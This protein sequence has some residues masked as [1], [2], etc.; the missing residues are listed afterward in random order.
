MSEG[1]FPFPLPL[2]VLYFFEFFLHLFLPSH[3]TSMSSRFVYP[4]HYL[5]LPACSRLGWVGAMASAWRVSGM[6][7]QDITEKGIKFS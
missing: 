7:R 6:L 4:P 3:A 2:L 5:L 1:D